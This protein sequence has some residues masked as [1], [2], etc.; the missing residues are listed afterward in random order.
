MDKYCSRP[1]GVRG[2]S[3]AA[4]HTAARRLAPVLALGLTLWAAAASPA[5]SPEEILQAVDNVRAPGPTFTFDL[6]LTYSRPRRSSVVQKFDVGVK[7]GTKSLVRFTAP[8]D[9]RGRVLLMVG[10]NMWMYM[11]TVNQPIRISAQQRLLGAV[12]N[13]DVARV[14]YSYDYGAKLLGTE[15]LTTVACNKLELTPK[16]PEAAY[17]RIVLWADVRTHQPIQAQFYATTGKLLKTAFYKGYQASLGKERP[18]LV[19]IRDEIREGEVSHLE[20]SNF[21]IANT[22]DSYFTKENL[23]YVR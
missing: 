8:E 10:Q 6:K 21:R 13:A 4:T 20:Y 17:G 15:T 3:R 9:V 14:V 23:R 22:P 16:T 1:P 5:A 19:E 18:M 12:S 2:G 7:E 11:P